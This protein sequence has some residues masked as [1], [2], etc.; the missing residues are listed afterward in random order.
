MSCSSTSSRIAAVDSSTV[1]RARSAIM[2]TTNSA[3]AAESIG[4]S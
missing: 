2:A 1:P 3:V 4:R